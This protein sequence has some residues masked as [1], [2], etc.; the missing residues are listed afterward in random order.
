MQHRTL[1]LSQ[2]MVSVISALAL[3]LTVLVVFPVGTAYAATTD[4]YVG[5]SGKSNNY[6]TVQAAVDKAASINPTSE[7]QRV[8]IH[9]APGTYRQQVVVQTPYIKFVNDEP[10]K[11]DVLLTWYYG[12]GYK[13]YSANS[14]GYYDSSLA[15]SKSGKNVANYRWGATVQLWPKATYFQAENI[16]FEN[17]FNRYITSE[18]I[19]DGVECTNETLTVARKSGV[20]VQSKSYTE[21][22]AAFSADAAYCEFLNCKFY[23]SQDTLYTGG[24]PQY[25]KHCLIEGQT[26]YIFGGSNA[27]FDQ[28]EL[29][30]KGYSS[31]S[32]G[33]YITAAR[34]QGDS[35]T[36]Y[37]FSD[38]KVTANPDLTVTA[39][40]LGRPWAQTAK[41]M[42]INTTL[43]NSSMINAAGWY[44]MSGVQPETVDGFKENGTKLA[45]GT[46]VD[47]SKRKG[48]II[49]DSD[50]AN[51]KL[52][53]YMNNWTPA[54]INGS[55]SSSSGTTTPAV[56]ST[57]LISSLSVKDSTY[58]SFWSL[59]E[60]TAV[61]AKAFG[62]RDFTI[63]SLP[64][65][66]S[67][68]DH[69][70]T[71]C[72]SKKTDADLAVLTAAKDITVYV[73]MDQRNVT[74]PAWL[75]SFKKTGYILG[76]T[77]GEGEKPFDIY[78]IDI[79]SGSSLTLGTNGMMGSVMGYT[80]F[81]AP[82]PRED[83]KSTL[84]S[85]LTVKDETYG[86][87]WSL[88][89]YT[90]VGAKAFGDRDF[91]IT[92][93]PDILAGA[94]HIVTACDSKK[95][96]ADLAVLTAAKDITVYVAMD[97]RNVT[98]PA[99]LGSFTK[100]GYI[101]GVTDGEGEKPFDVYAID[102]KAGSSLT[103]GTNGMM[104]SVMGYTAF[105]TEYKEPAPVKEVGVRGD[106]N[107]DGKADLFDAI[108]VM[109]YL[110][111]PYNSAI[112]EQGKLNADVVG[113][114]GLTSEDAQQI[115]KFVTGLVTEL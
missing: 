72:D 25:Y 69:I 21:R 65:I 4:L 71:A 31:G 8:T 22:A 98:L 103:L 13:Y 17:S 64:D 11:G 14:K 75:S 79:K 9:I 86:E 68:A 6:S 27:V 78:S 70:V 100:T 85:K 58:G 93:L 51:I 73:A 47:L 7:S 77:D 48:H 112:S 15:K 5:Y 106:A 83:L 41:V 107:C 91:T 37:L 49:S 39:G 30:W 74:L 56:L 76:V 35:Y 97:Q 12:I 44:S 43:Q 18:E 52:K 108:L 36:G 96:D 109:Q 105:V 87:Y 59:A 57:S 90:Y 63:T 99:W 102:L 62:D 94:E 42:F 95:T 32:T 10:S 84:I 60:N 40:Y 66:L 3:V 92:T 61:G 23:S 113:D 38:C 88:D 24:S 55:A 89:S 16:V 53:N 19:A 26:D 67:G 82:T 50:A 111:D 45:N 115:Q 110:A 34:E 80:A 104:G 54:F 28:C 1:S 81:A 29:R 33:G 20:D 46:A 101:L 114:N 2:R